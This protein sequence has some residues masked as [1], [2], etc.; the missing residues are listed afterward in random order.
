M[1]LFQMDWAYYTVIDGNLYNYYDKVFD[2]NGQ[3]EPFKSL[4]EA[5]QWLQDNDIRGN[6]TEFQS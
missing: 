3:H 6:A 4:E 1:A 5:E 2:Y